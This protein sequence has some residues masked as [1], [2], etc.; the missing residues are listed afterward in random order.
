MN[1]IIKNLVAHLRG[2]A[3]DSIEILKKGG[4]LKTD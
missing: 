4:W 1:D 3:G 2:I